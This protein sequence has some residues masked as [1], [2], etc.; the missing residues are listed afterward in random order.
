MGRPSKVRYR[1]DRDAWV[2]TIGGRYVTLARGR[3]NRAEAMQAFHRLQAERSPGGLAARSLVSVGELFDR[4]LDWTHENRSPLTYGT[5]KQDLDAFAAYIGPATPADAVRPHHVDDYLAGKAWSDM[6]RRRAITGL[7]RA[8]SWGR[9]RGLIPVDHLA[10]MEKPPE[11]RRES[12]LT[13]AEERVVLGAA[14][15]PLADYLAMMHQT[16]MRPSEVARVEAAHHFPAD[17][18]LRFPGK[19]TPRTG[20]LR[21]VYLTPEAAAIVARLAAATPEGPIFRNTRGR[22]WTRNALA[23]AMRRL[24][25][26]VKAPGARTPEER[27]AA[28]K[29][30]KACTAESFRHGWVTDAKLKLK[31]G[32]AAELADH[33]STAMIDKWYGHVSERREELAAAAALVR[34]AGTDTPSPPAGG[35]PPADP[36]PAAPAPPAGGDRTPRG[37][38]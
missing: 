33:R 14:T 30:W 32:V 7:K 31:N 3:R 9:K 29:G 10:V 37:G 12:I 20:R 25:V 4:L 13:P 28:R 17:G 38:S 1:E 18:M 36:P 21:H 19:S 35:P 24:R 5:Y 22:P 34:G 16:G 8:F 2:T 27:E 26:K 23:L 15:G 6:T 11:G